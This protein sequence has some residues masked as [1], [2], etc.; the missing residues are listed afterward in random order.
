VF[1]KSHFSA[2]YLSEFIE[3]ISGN[4]MPHKEKKHG[5]GHHGHG[6]HHQLK[7]AK[8]FDPPY[9]ADTKTGM[10]DVKSRAHGEGQSRL[11]IGS[12]ANVDPHP[13]MLS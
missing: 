7:S 8:L 3:N 12:S 10:G 4:K 2:L 9:A 1:E 11:K 5:H 6:R 13:L